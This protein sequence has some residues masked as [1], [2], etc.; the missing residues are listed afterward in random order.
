[1]ESRLQNLRQ[2]IYESGPETNTCSGLDNK[3]SSDG[4]SLTFILSYLTRLT[5]ERL[6][7]NMRSVGRLISIRH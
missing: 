7:R 2:I 3:K 1:M 5:I 6:S 4:Y